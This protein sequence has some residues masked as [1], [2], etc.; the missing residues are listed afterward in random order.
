MKSRLMWAVLLG[1]LACVAGVLPARNAQAAAPAKVYVIDVH[2][3]VQPGQAKFVEEHLDEAARNGAAAVILD[4]DTFGGLADSAVAIK[5]AVLSHDRDFVTV[6]YVHSRALSSGSLIT[7]SCKYIAMAPGATLGAAQPHPGFTGGEPDPEML[8]WARKEFESTAESR[9]RNPSIAAAWVTAPSAMPSLGIKEGDILTLTTDQAKTN[10]YC[11]V[12]ASDYPDIL[13]FLKLSDAQVIPEH[14][15][16]WLNAAIFITDPWITIIL[17]G[18]GI[19]AVVLEMITLHS[20]GVAGIIGAAFVA[21]V[22]AAYIIAGMASWIGL[23]LFVG[24]IALIMLESHFLPTHGLATLGGVVCMAVGLFLALGGT[25]GNA[26]LPASMSMVVSLVAMAA[27][28]AYLPKSRI[29]RILGS[30]SQQKA[31][32]GYVSSD[33]YT[34]YL[35]SRGVAISVLRPS[36]TAEIE[37]ARLNVVTEGGFVPEGTPIEVTHV[38][39]NRIVV[40]SLSGL[41]GLG[42]AQHNAEQPR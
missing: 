19:A 4:V 32:A 34:G 11:D 22:F 40:R 2:G 27:F 18:L 12:V 13:S 14:L 36:G 42:A 9:N 5:D 25:S 17:L 39:G 20:W 10:G 28:F 24:G 26:L 33:D 15:D 16:F 30:G 31:T 38:Q 3:M 8:S 37:G 7:L 21:I 6:G 41:V 23:L 1:L 29:W 35:G